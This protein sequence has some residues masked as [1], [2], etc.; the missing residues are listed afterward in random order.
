[1]NSDKASGIFHVCLERLAL[2]YGMV[3]M[4]RLKSI[5]SDRHYSR[6]IADVLEFAA[7]FTAGLEGVEQ[8]GAKKMLQ[9]A[10]KRFSKFAGESQL[11][12][13]CVHTTSARSHV[14]VWINTYDSVSV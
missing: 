7:V 14:N 1:M 12:G 4:N 3:D 13:E 6:G 11:S 10:L 8:N 2:H 5:G 9:A